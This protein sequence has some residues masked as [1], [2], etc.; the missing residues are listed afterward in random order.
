MTEES[1]SAEETAAQRRER[2]KALREAQQLL[3]SEHPQPQSQPQPQPPQQ[4]EPQVEEEA[5]Q[6]GKLDM[7]F[8]NYLPRDKKLQEN[9]IAPPAL[10]KF[11]DPVATAPPISN[12]TEDPIVNIAPKKPNW[13]L[14]RDVQKKLDKLDRRTQRAIIELMQEEEKRRQEAAEQTNEAVEED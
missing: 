9:R 13:D 11:D 2:L 6:D 1:G 5:E 7:K 12:G 14:R 10:P 8:R 3:D 4:I